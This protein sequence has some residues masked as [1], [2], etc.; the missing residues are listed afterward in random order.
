MIVKHYPGAE[1]PSQT[2]NGVVVRAEHLPKSFRAEAMQKGMTEELNPSYF[3]D[4]FKPKK[5]L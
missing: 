4:K 1:L 3:H 2:L 5:R